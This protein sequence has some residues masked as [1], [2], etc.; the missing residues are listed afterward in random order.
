[1]KHSK[2]RMNLDNVQNLYDRQTDIAYLKWCKKYKL[3]TFCCLTFFRIDQQLAYKR[4]AANQKL[5]IERNQ[6]LISIDGEQYFKYN[7]SCYKSCRV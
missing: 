2:L 5:L 3:K 4:F 1:M 7:K 6:K